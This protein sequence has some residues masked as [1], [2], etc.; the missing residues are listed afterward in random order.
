MAELGREYAGVG[1]LLLDGRYELIRE[2]R[3]S[4]GGEKIKIG[5]RF[6]CRYCSSQDRSQFRTEAHTFPE[7]LGN[8]WVISQDECDI[9]NQKFSVYEGA[10]AA[11]VSPFLTLGG[12]EG[13]NSTVRQTGR[14][15]GNAVLKRSPTGTGR[16]HISAVAVGF[17]LPSLAKF[18]NHGKLRLNIPIAGVPFKPR[19]AYKALAKMGF[20]LLPEDE[21]THY[22]N[23]RT[24]LMDIND[25]V[26]FPHLE[27]GMSF[28]SV[29]KSPPFVSGSILRRVNPLGMHPHMLFIYCSGSVCF[30]IDLLSDHLESHIPAVPIGAIKIQYSVV[31]GDETG[32]RIIEFR[33]GNPTPLNWSSQTTEPQP[34]ETM[35]FDF[36]PET[37]KGNFTPVFRAIG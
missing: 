11:A 7:A 6:E 2:V 29:G 26:E 36:D 34:I 14:S 23:L 33:Y 17:D 4:I 18:D 27:C 10:L 32:R 3:G 25:T 31:V 28:A 15:A 37:L 21:V 16:P 20:S 30:Q 35:V 1:S 9:C 8:K 12:V 19:H 24:W 5:R 13:K 22:G